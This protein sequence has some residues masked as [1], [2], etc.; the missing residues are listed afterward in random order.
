MQGWNLFLYDFIFKAFKNSD[1]ITD[2]KIFWER[3]KSQLY[4]NATQP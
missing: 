2:F 3:A 4:E 1:I